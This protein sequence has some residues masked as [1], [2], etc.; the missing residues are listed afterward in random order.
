MSI[1]SVIADPELGSTA[2]TVERIRHTRGRKGTT[3]SSRTARAVGCVHPGTPEMLQLLPEEEKNETCIVIYT[4]YA[5]STGT[6]ED[7]GASFTAPDR[8]HWKGR[9]WRVEGWKCG[10]L[11]FTC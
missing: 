2:F 8:I 6:P 3:C 7:A 4:D 5:L 9:T 1:I 11:R 10:R